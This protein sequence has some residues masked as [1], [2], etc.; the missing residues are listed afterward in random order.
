MKLLLDTNA[1]IWFANGDEK[2]SK[3]AI[4]AIENPQNETFVSVANIWEIAI[5]KSL[6]KLEIDFELKDI[7]IIILSNGFKLLNILAKHAISIED[8]PPIHKDLFDRILFSQAL[9]E[10]MDIISV[11]EIFDRYTL[12]TPINRVW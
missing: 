1:L 10:N 2:L 8:L 5:K 9:I 4:I 3:K 7:E 6:G 12:D 11:D